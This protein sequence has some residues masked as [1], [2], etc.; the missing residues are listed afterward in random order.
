MAVLI[1]EQLA[2]RQPVRDRKR[3]ITE[4]FGERLPHRHA[5]VGPTRKSASAES[6]EQRT[7]RNQGSGAEH[8]R[9]RRQK[10]K[11]KSDKRTER[12]RAK[13]TR[14]PFKSFACARNQ[15]QHECARNETDR[16]CERCERQLRREKRDLATFRRAAGNGRR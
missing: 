8:E 16:G 11:N 4:P 5:Q 7:A 3:T 13:V 6:R 14:T 1:D 2:L 12:P 10:E 15:H 9:S